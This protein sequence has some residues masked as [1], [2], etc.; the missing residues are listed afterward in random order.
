[1]VHASD[2]SQMS[3]AELD[4]GLKNAEKAEKLVSKKML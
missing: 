4:Q 3:V 2:Y 1:M